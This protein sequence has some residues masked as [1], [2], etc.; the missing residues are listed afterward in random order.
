M[1]SKENQ[2]PP[3]RFPSNLS[4]INQWGQVQY[5]S[6]Q[7]QVECIDSLG[8]DHG[9]LGGQPPRKIYEHPIGFD[10]PKNLLLVEDHQQD[11]QKIRKLAPSCTKYGRSNQSIKINSPHPPSLPTISSPN[12]KSFLQGYHLQI[13]KLF[14]KTYNHAQ[15]WALVALEKVYFPKLSGGLG[16]R[17]P[18]ILIKHLWLN[19]WWIWL[20]RGFETWKKISD[21]KYSLSG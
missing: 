21:R 16:L 19:L 8:L 12:S 1:V 10:L 2:P 18:K 20:Q 17:Y 3:L 5:I 13:Q 15:K 6:L 7:Y 4:Y 14:M 9:I 11:H